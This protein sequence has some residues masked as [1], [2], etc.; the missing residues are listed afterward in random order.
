MSKQ[1]LA[2]ILCIMASV[3]FSQTNM[4]RSRGEG[5]YF[6][7]NANTI[8][9]G[10][11]WAHVRMLGFIW[12]A[13]TVRD[14]NTQKPEPYAFPEIE[15]EVG[16]FNI[17]SLH[18]KL[19]PI[20]YG[21]SFGWLSAGTKF[22][23]LKNKD[24]RLNYV[25]LKLDYHHSFAK[26]VTSS[27]AGYR[28]TKGTGFS[29]EGF[30]YAGGLFKIRAL[31]DADFLKKFSWLPLKLTANIGANIPLNKEFIDYTQYTI[32]VGAAYVGH[33]S[34]IFI[35]YGLEAF[36]NSS[37][38][39][40]QFKFAWPGWQS[41]D[42]TTLEYKVWEVAFPENP[43]YLTIGGRIR[44]PNGIVL[45]GALPLLVSHNVGSTTR[46]SG[47]GAIGEHTIIGNFPE[48]YAR[49]V[50]DGFDPWYAKWKIVLQFTIPL[51]YRLTSS[52]MRR[53]FLLLKN[54][55]D[56]KRIDIDKR[57]ELEKDSPQ[58]KKEAEE[59]D[60]KR[61]LKEIEERRKKIE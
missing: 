11:T 21:K 2:M 26:E 35:E 16:L 61:R 6:C 54:K 19:R 44:Y 30:I 27:I 53:N 28:D 25:G 49:G 46:H 24:L 12:D 38:N 39:P 9:A 36:A 1:L 58:E 50:T 17:A 7:E 13:E 56:K 4:N 45:Y 31:Y 42:N 23:F 34:D 40:K 20:T 52:E 60:K 43:M 3:L 18:V 48:E 57:I 29:P 8:G 51:R 47:R 14:E 37:N 32:A 5:L 55:R 59:K 15:G 22:T 33:G 41:G 10:N